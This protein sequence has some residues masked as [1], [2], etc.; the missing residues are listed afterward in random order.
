MYH[1]LLLDDVHFSAVEL[2]E[3]FDCKVTRL[4]NHSK[5]EI[6]NIIESVDAIIYRLFTTTLDNEILSKAKKLR[7][8]VRTGGGM[9]KIDL[10]IIREKKVKIM[11]TNHCNSFSAAEFIF[12]SIL[13]LVRKIALGDKLFRSGHYERQNLWGTELAGKTLGII[14]FGKIGKNLCM[15]ANAFNMNVISFSPHITQQEEEMYKMKSVSLDNLYSKSDI[16]SIAFPV[17]K[18]FLGMINKDTIKLMK[19]GVFLI[20]ATTMRL[21]NYEDTANALTEGKI[22]SELS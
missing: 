22:A 6:L 14:G 21:F 19:N 12:G 2:L 3:S 18:E 5:Q 10:D 20:N 4:I 11:D 17:T 13:T 1:V 15:M 7:C 9:G 8:I 16:I